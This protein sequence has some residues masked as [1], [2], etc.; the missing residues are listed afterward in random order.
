MPTDPPA[1]SPP[2][3]TPDRG[4]PVAGHERL[5]LAVVP[6][7]AGSWIKDGRPS[8]AAFAYPLFSSDVFGD[9][10]AERRTTAAAFLGRPGRWPAGTRA[11]EYT[12]AAAVTCDFVAHHCPEPFSQTDLQ[13][14]EAHANVYCDHGNSQ[15]KKRARE[16]A[17]HQTSVVRPEVSG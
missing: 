12:V 14:N 13:V 17:E 4:P 2:S 11:I 9:E 8:S 16:L 10:P 7:L 3:L 15:R 6:R 5:L 1:D